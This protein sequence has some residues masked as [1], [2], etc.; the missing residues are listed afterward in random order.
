MA[1]ST[2]EKEEN[3]ARSLIEKICNLTERI[4][5]TV[6]LATDTSKIFSAFSRSE[7]DAES[8]Y[9]TF[10]RRFDAVFGKDSNDTEG[11]LGLKYLERGPMGMDL[12]VSYLRSLVSEDILLSLPLSLINIKLER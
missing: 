3:E 10:N 6:P 9:F 1:Q 4:P 8:E 2:E 5:S 7:T 11:R 12:V